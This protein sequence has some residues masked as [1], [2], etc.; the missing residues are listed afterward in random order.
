MNLITVTLGYTR[1]STADGTR[2][3]AGKQGYDLYSG[4][5]IQYGSPLVTT[6]PKSPA[7]NVVI[8]EELISWIFELYNCIKPHPYPYKMF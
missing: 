7:H 1:M 6:I 2:V 4:K 5:C 3:E 8:N